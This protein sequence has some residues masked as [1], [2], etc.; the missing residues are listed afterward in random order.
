MNADRDELSQLGSALDAMAEQLATRDAQL[1]NALEQLQEQ[2]MTDPLT[3]LYNRRFF[4]DALARACKQAQR[5]QRAFSVILM[6]LDHFKN[7]NDSYG[8]DA[9]DA[10]LKHVGDLLRE[11]VRASD[12]AVRYGGEEFAILLPDTDTEVAVARAEGLR[13][14]LRAQPIDCGKQSIGITASFGVAEY[15]YATSTGHGLMQSA[16]AALYAAK[17][18]GRNAVRTAVGSHRRATF[19]IDCQ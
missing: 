4:N 10:V 18:D 12:I 9:G 3:G 8:H 1:R 13:L 17:A 6:D 7:V 16:D 11:R 15:E 5:Q 2:A 19:Q 14:A